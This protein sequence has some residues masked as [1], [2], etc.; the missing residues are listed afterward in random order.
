M[1]K[2]LLRSKIVEVP[3]KKRFN[4]KEGVAI[5]AEDDITTLEEFENEEAALKALPKYAAITN[6]GEYYIVEEYYVA[7]CEYKYNDVL[8]E[9]EEIPESEYILECSRIKIELIETPS[10]DRIATFDNM[11]DAEESMDDYCYN[12]ENDDNEVYL[13][14]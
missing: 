4:I 2:Y 13:K 10:Y 8:E 7:R 12:N 1:I 3:Y 5:N 9:Y 14:F 11:K 6:Y